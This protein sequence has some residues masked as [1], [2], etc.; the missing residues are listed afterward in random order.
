MATY[1]LGHALF[2]GLLL[3]AVHKFNA[4]AIKSNVW[5]LICYGPVAVTVCLAD[6]RACALGLPKKAAEL[7]VSKFGIGA[8]AVMG[9]VYVLFR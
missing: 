9:A 4:H 8:I 5:L 6:I 7:Y 1:L 2:S 3:M